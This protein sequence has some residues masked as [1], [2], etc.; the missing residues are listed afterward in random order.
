MPGVLTHQGLL[1]FMKSV[2]TEQKTQR[3][4]AGV[5]MPDASLAQALGADLT[6]VRQLLSEL[7]EKGLIHRTSL[8]RKTG[9]GNWCLG[10]GM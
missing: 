1:E 9:I 4:T 3:Y 10:R 2:A 5:C 6:Y 7:A 8:D